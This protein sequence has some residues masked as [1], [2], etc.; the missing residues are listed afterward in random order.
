MVERELKDY[1]EQLEQS[2]QK[3]LAS[4]FQLAKRVLDSDKCELTLEVPNDT[5]KKELQLA[6]AEALNFLSDRLSNDFLHF[7]FKRSKEP[8]S[9]QYA[10]TPDEKYQKL[11][12]KYPQVEALRKRFNLDL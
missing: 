8:I 2:G 12:E 9:T 5:I 7:K 3:I 6:A 1:A 4:N 11:A 10:Y